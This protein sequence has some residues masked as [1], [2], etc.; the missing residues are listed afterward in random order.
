MRADDRKKEVLKSVDAAAKQKPACRAGLEKVSQ[1][2]KRDSFCDVSI[3][4]FGKEFREWQ[5]KAD[6]ACSQMLD[7]V[8]QAV[9][10]AIGDADLDDIV[11]RLSDWCD[12]KENFEKFK[13]SYDE[14]VFLEAIVS[15]QMKTEMLD[16]FDKTMDEVAVFV[17][18]MEEAGGFFDYDDKNILDTLNIQRKA[19]A[20]TEIPNSAAAYDSYKK[21]K[22]SLD[23][24]RGGIAN[25]NEFDISEGIRMLGDDVDDLVT[26]AQ[27]GKLSKSKQLDKPK[28]KGYDATAKMQIREANP[29]DLDELQAGVVMYKI[30]A[31]DNAE[32]ARVFGKSGDIAGSNT[33]NPANDPQIKQNQKRLERLFASYE[34]AKTDIEKTSI[35]N[36]ISELNRDIEERTAQL[37]KKAKEG[38]PS[39]VYA[40]SYK[41]MGE[42]MQEFMSYFI[43]QPGQ[44]KLTM[45]KYKE[46]LGDIESNLNEVRKRFSKKIEINSVADLVKLYETAVANNDQEQIDNIK[47]AVQVVIENREK[48]APRTD[49]GVK[50]RMS[51]EELEAAKQEQER[52]RKEAEEMM[53]KQAEERRNQED[54][55][56]EM[57]RKMGLAVDE[58]EAPSSDKEAEDEETLNGVLEEIE[59]M[60]NADQ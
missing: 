5:Y 36:Q 59:K 31:Q 28:F 30:Q 10:A 9:T 49:E 11:T 19:I 52:A 39:K 2:L 38:G 55:I 48:E 16:L 58:P 37:M 50:E 47:T 15:N 32:I 8:S 13:E 51:D 14:G 41:E 26:D 3:D 29:R 60:K 22:Q 23:R 54:Q 12:T 35:F 20:N 17:P 4:G 43:L 7:R 18:M 56:R 33:Y 24:L 53:K 42:Y 57:K 27:K 45:K 21:M 40:E 34:A 44:Y 46:Y 6:E 1:I 25:G